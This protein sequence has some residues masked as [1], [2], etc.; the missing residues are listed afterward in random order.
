MCNVRIKCAHLTRG[1][2]VVMSLS[3]THTHTH[4]ERHRWSDDKSRRQNEYFTIAWTASLYKWKRLSASPTFARKLFF[5]RRW[6]V[7]VDQTSHLTLSWCDK[8]IYIYLT[9]CVGSNGSLIEAFF[10]LCA[11]A[12]RL[13]SVY[14]IANAQHSTY[15]SARP[16]RISKSRA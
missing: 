7:R 11:D 8:Y 4:R 6:A 12:D 14:T 15:T 3:Q 1:K 2:N 16:V 5:K 10:E 13:N 9:Y